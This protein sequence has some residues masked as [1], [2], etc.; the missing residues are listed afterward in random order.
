MFALANLGQGIA[1]SVYA[2][3]WRATLAIVLVAQLSI[4]FAASPA[5]GVAVTRGSFQLDTAGV[6]GTGTIFDGSMVE[7]GKASSELKLQSG[8]NMVLG[9]G[10]RGQIYRDHLLLEKGTGQL[11][12]GANYRIKARSLQIEPVSE[13]AA[14][15]TVS[16]EGNRVL[17]AALGGGVRVRTTRGVLVADV[18]AG[19]ALSFEPQEAG[20]S[21]PT[22]LTGVVVK[23]NGHYYLTDETAGVTVELQGQGLDKE[24]GKKVKV[25]GIVDPSGSPGN[26]AS[27]V[28]RVTQL[29][30]ISGAGAGAAASAGMAA[31]TKAVIAGVVVAGAATGTAVGLT[32]DEKAPIS[33]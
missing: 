13:G 21:A 5:I 9:S 6:S 18:P 12:N 3:T 26:G 19:R 24:V 4:G 33:Q 25:V 2:M 27:Q 10:T 29:S 8:V 31:G 11:T 28:V 30:Q 7:T 15:V 23:K 17:V 22:E 20:A 32:R 1:A 14:K 16:R